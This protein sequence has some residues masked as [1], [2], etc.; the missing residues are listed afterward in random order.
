MSLISTGGCSVTASLYC[1]L[2]V[3]P[4][5]MEP[6]QP[7]DD[8]EQYYYEGDDFHDEDE[9]EQEEEQHEGE[10]SVGT[11]GDLL[12]HQDRLALY[13]IILARQ[14]PSNDNAVS[15][16]TVKARQPLPQQPPQTR[17]RPQY[18]QE[19]GKNGYAM[20]AHHNR[21]A[22][23]HAV[24]K[25]PAVQH[26][27]HYGADAEEGYYDD[28]QPQHRR[29]HIQHRTPEVRMVQADGMRRQEEGEH[30]I[31]G[32]HPQDHHPHHDPQGKKGCNKTFTRAE[33]LGMHREN[34]RLLES[35]V[36]IHVSCLRHQCIFIL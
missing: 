13:D 1:L 10:E 4:I 7:G 33:L 26:R 31:M 14:D 30:M 21:K 19:P 35:M 20:A 24:K 34:N 6:S 25:A 2:F 15:P 29:H 11:M 18:D 36:R 3:L 8:D 17:T 28:E 9:N 5:E 23:Q 32:T 16:P 27:N 22:P 12:S